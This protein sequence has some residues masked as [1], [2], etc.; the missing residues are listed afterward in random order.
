MSLSQYASVMSMVGRVVGFMPAQLKTWSM[1]SKAII[2]FETNAFAASVEPTSK[3]AMIWLP[4]LQRES[5]SS[6]ETGS[7]SARARI[8]PRDASLMLVARPI[9]LPAPVTS[10]T[11][12]LNDGGMVRRC[13]C[14]EKEVV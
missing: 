11:L 7:M 5:V 8:A 13:T 2:A 1:R 12:S 9:P 10:I 14:H 4:F 3:V 6:R